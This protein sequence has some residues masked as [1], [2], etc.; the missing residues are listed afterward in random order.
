[1]SPTCPQCPQALVF[2]QLPIVPGGTGTSYCPPDKEVLPGFPRWDTGTSQCPSLGTGQ[3]L[4]HLILPSSFSTVPKA[5]TVFPKAWALAGK[6]WV[7][8]RLWVTAATRI[9]RWL[10]TSSNISLMVEAA[11]MASLALVAAAVL[12]AVVQAGC[13]SGT[14]GDTCG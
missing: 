14:F 1:M 3:T 6:P 9:W 11:L 8:S 7:T 2:P 12:V 4:Q 5:T 10:V 13:D